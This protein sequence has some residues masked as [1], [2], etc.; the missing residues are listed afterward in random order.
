MRANQTRPILNDVPSTTG[1]ASF[2]PASKL[3][4]MEYETIALCSASFD[5]FLQRNE[6]KGEHRFRKLEG[7]GY[8]SI[9]VALT[10]DRHALLVKYDTR[11]QFE[12]SLQIWRDIHVFR[13]DFYEVFKL[14][15]VPESTIQWCDG[16]VLWK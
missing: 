6:V 4:R 3:P 5:D 10:N 14:L 15:A 9:G 1:V 8:N 11:P 2:M 7:G 12:I 16:P 13:E